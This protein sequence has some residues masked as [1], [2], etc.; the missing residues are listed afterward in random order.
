MLS[1]GRWVAIVGF[2]GTLALGVSTTAAAGDG[3]GAQGNGMAALKHAAAADKY[4][5]V[6]F[7]KGDDQQTQAMRQVF[8]AV[9]AKISEKAECIV[10][11]TKDAS[12][13]GIVT[14]FDAKRSPMPLVMTIAPNGAITG[15][16]P[17]KFTEELLMGAFVSPST[18]GCLKAL[19]DGKM[20]LLCVQ[21][22]ETEFAPEALQAARAV[23]ADPKYAKSTAIVIVDPADKAEAKAM[24]RLKIG[25]DADEAITILMAPPGTIISRIQGAATKK[26]LMAAVQSALDKA[27]KPCC[28]G[29]KCEPKKPAG[30]KK[31]KTVKRRS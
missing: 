14:K 7:H 19:Q 17:L 4:L 29:G 24:Q 1:K 16:F 26:S 20:V 25:A 12:E 10:I 2:A 5:F 21:N 30:K 28:P 31:A 18:A 9:A 13:R 23:N 8:D 27:K 6:F 15:G 3:A 11:D 22:S